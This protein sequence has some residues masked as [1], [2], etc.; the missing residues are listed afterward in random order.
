MIQAKIDDHC[1][2]KQMFSRPRAGLKEVADFGIDAEICFNN[3][4][5]A[6]EHVTKISLGN[7]SHIQGNVRLKAEKHWY[8][9][10]V[11]DSNSISIGRHHRRD[12]LPRL[13]SGNL[14]LRRSRPP[15]E[16]C[17]ARN[18][19]RCFGSAG[20]HNQKFFNCKLNWVHSYELDPFKNW[21]FRKWV[22]Y[23]MAL[24]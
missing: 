12:C 21:T 13:S 18:H 6:A 3:L 14:W 19:S 10:F 11:L 1:F 16:R 8:Q 17:W 5:L 20:W 15:S 7:L 24:P 22:R 23:I 4:S 9:S 2:L